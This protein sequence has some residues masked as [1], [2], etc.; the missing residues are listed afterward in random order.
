MMRSPIIHLFTLCLALWC[1]LFGHA[2]TRALQGG[3]FFFDTDPGEGAGTAFAAVD[4]AFDE[5]FEAAL[6]STSGLSIGTHTLHVRLLE[7]SGAWSPVFRTVISVE[8]PTV[9][10]R[11]VS[12]AQAEYFWDTDPG[13][14]SA[15]PLLVFDG[16]FNEAFEQVFAD[17]QNSPGL[18]AHILNVRLRGTDGAWSA[19]FR[20][21]VSVEEPTVSLRAV[22]IAQAEYFWDTDPG[23]GSATPLLAF[24]GA[25]DEA[26]EQVFADAQN[27]PGLGAHILN[28]RMRG[29][30]GAWSAVFRTVITVEEPTVPLRAVA[31]TQA[32]Y[33]W[34]MDPGEGSA[35]PLL[36]FDGAFDE[37]FEQAFADAQNSPGLGAHVLNVR[38]R[39]SDGTWS[40]LF[41]T[42]VSVE[43]PSVPL[44]AVSVAQA[45][46]YWDVDPGEGNATAMNASDA[47]YDAPFEE[48]LA[49]ATTQFLSEGPHVLGIRYRA[50]NGAWSSSFR[51]V[52]HLEPDPDAVRVALK[53]MLDGP[54]SAT[55]GLM[56]DALRSA[57]LIPVT[58]PY[59]ALGYSF[60]GGGGDGTVPAT[61]AT[62]GNDAVVDWVALELRDPND[63]TL[64]LHSR[65]ALLQRD[66]DV[67]D[68]NGSSPVTFAIP[69]GDYHLVALHRIHLAAM[70]SAP[71]TFGNGTTTIDLSN[72]STPTFGTAAQKAISGDHPVNALWAGDVNFD[73]SIRYTGLMNDRDPI[74]VDIGGTVATSTITGYLSTDVNMDGTA[75]Y[76]GS[77]NDR[78]IILQNIGGVVPTNTRSEQLP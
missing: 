78:D 39:G 47:L 64:T 23:E 44:R 27:S 1:P 41:R 34:D 46:Y 51:T 12:I 22:A 77:S 33:F 54:Y 10:L 59:T 35:S 72:G 18:G 13:E 5:A 61:F 32:E 2:Q 40:A 37:A 57:S 17:A 55:T 36:A 50:A 8:A 49:Q 9:P 67:V 56:S 6:A 68:L 15:A 71:I 31:I 42:V 26:F 75:K 70:T 28:V 3:E 60:T 53:L 76:T 30:D 20:T 74:L 38:V 24:D 19:V 58:E 25:F 14:G 69:P 16:A 45:E 43:A 4:G 66:G 52:V 65:S 21:V 11:A 7:A 62:S 73:G 63:P 29:P 48:A